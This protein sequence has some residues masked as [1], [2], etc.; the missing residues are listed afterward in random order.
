MKKFLILLCL[1]TISAHAEEEWWEA[2]NKSGGKIVLLG[3]ECTPKPELKTLKRM[4]AAHK[5]GQT[6]WGC[7]NY[8]SNQVHVVYDNGESYTYDAELFTRKTLP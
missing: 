7:W 2:P 6:F 5:D 3:G 1:V 4:Y 8:W